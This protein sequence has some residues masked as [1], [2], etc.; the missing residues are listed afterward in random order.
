MHLSAFYISYIAMLEGSERVQRGRKEGQEGLKR[1][2]RGWQGGPQEAA[3]RWKGG[4]KRWSSRVSRGFQVRTQEGQTSQT[5]SVDLLKPSWTSRPPLADLSLTL[6][7]DLST[8]LLQHIRVRQRG[9]GPFEAL[10]GQR[11]RRGHEVRGPH[12]EVDLDGVSS[13]KRK[14]KNRKRKNRKR[15]NRKQKNRK[16]KNRKR[17]DRTSNEK[18]ENKNSSAS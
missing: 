8:D 14:R 10:R 4:R 13:K 5:L 16:R 17:K 18:V 11:G 1:D 7:T 2:A 12:E 6:S 3:G 15:K 9:Q